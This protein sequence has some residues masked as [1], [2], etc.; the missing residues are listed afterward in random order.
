MWIEEG[1]AGYRAKKLLV[2]SSCP[3]VGEGTEAQQQTSEGNDSQ[4]HFFFFL[5]YEEIGPS[6]GEQWL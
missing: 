3:Q 1:V 6:N 5:P 2:S 4:W